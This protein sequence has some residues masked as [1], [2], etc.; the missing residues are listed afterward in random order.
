MDDEPPETFINPYTFVPLP[1]EPPQREQPRG[2]LGAPDPNLL[3]G[4]LAITIT[5]RSPVLI[6]G[7]PA[8]QD[9]PARQDDPAHKD[10][11]AHEV[12]KET[13]R[14]PTRPD[15]TQII[16]GSAL[17]GAIRSLHETL[18]GSCLRVLH[19]EF[20]PVYRHLAKP[21]E[22]NE[23]RP[24]V[25]RRHDD[26]SQPPE[27]R[28]CKPGN[29]RTDRVH[30]DLLAKL[31]SEDNPL[32]AGDSLIVHTRDE[33]KRPSN[34]QRS[35]DTD[36]R[37]DRWVLFLTDASV[38]EAQQA[39]YRAQIR[40][41]DERTAQLSEQAWKDYLAALEG[42]DDQRRA[43]IEERGDEQVTKLVTY[44]TTPEDHSQAAHTS[45]L[46]RRY[47]ARKKLTP[48]QPVWVRLNEDGKTVD[49]LRLS[50]LWR[51][52]AHTA[53]AGERAG[54]FAPCQ[55]EKRLCPSCQ[56]FGSAEDTDSAEPA[57]VE[58]GSTPRKPARQH[59]YRGHVRFGDA[60]VTKKVEDPDNVT[61]PPL[62]TPHP[63]SGQFYLVA[64]KTHQNNAAPDLPLREW[65][66]VADAGS[67]RALRGRKY[68]WH[69]P[70][71]TNELPERAKT[72][73]RQ[74]DQMSSEAEV[75][76]TGTRF[77]ATVTFTD[78]S[79]AQLG[80][81]LAALEPQSFLKDA[82]NAQVHIGGGRPLGFGSCTISVNEERSRVWSSGA[83]YG[84]EGSTTSR[85]SMSDLF[86]AFRTA[87]PAHLGRT[88]TH[89]GQ[90]LDPTAV[91][92]AK[93]TYPPGAAWRKRD[94]E[95]DA[96]DKGFEFWKHSSGTE[97]SA[98][99]GKRTGY[100]LI[101]L[102]HIGSGKQTLPLKSEAEQ[103]DINKDPLEW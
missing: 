96:F 61:V 4:A 93:V 103:Q 10:N 51:R 50:M 13:S 3:S 35:T 49:E 66:S 46:G 54:E 73:K 82:E 64:D 68:Y 58:S 6:R 90:A 11:P 92:H 32:T 8:H 16:P 94:D 56:V 24:A 84:A 18:T 2:H 23:L 77:T 45:H 22:I 100:P 62:G 86:N 52:V 20:V 43:N 70:T 41:F 89:L 38:R 59:S 72:H 87:M 28:L 83:R 34:V 55:D 78:L 29:P 17:K 95:P 60:H 7:F 44:T 30:Q 81:L 42:A 21:D 98:E 9:K 37:G 63:G 33:K 67:P 85:P 47:V 15:D 12:E 74:S 27:V 25:V 97:Y 79:R 80:G 71:G 5:A 40:K 88:L 1:S 26:E 36:N 14:L 102:P 101:P 69:T 19:S 76:P 91:D 39:P 53:S 65:G 31:H 57:L 99:S 48:G 75:F